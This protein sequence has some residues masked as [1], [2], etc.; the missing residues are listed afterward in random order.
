MDF[1][2]VHPPPPGQ[3]L[4]NVAAHVLLTQQLSPDQRAIM[5][6]DHSNPTPHGCLQRALLMPRQ[7]ST[8]DIRSAV[9]RNLDLL[10]PPTVS[11][12]EFME[13]AL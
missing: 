10:L 8:M 12:G 11:Q 5:I 7:V 13:I 9:P 4:S 1:Q 6:C 3:A 2:L